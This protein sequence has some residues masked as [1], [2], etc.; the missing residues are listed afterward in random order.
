VAAA[1][2]GGNPDCRFEAHS[3]FLAGP[4]P[5]TRAIQYPPR[6]RIRRGYAPRIL[7]PAWMWLAENRPMPAPEQQTFSDEMM[8]PRWRQPLLQRPAGHRGEF[9]HNAL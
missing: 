9:A 7:C 3:K 1:D 6:E 2:I 8:Q 5:R 4:A